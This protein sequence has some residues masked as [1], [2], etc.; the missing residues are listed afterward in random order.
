MKTQAAAEPH[1]TPVE[2]LDWA[3][4]AAHLDDNGFAVTPPLLAAEACRALCALFDQDG[5]FRKTVN[6]ARHNYGRGLY[7][8][9]DYPLPGAVGRLRDHLYPGLAAI[10]NQWAGRLGAPAEWP[11]ELPALLDR[12]HAAGQCKP[13]PLLLRYGPGDYNR[14]HQDLYGD[15]HFPLQVVIQLSEPGREFEGGELVLVEQR[16]RQQSRPMVVSL[17]QGAAAIIPV[18]ERPEA[19]ARGVRRVQMR[20]GVS[21][22]R[23]G[24]RTTLGL[25]FHDAQ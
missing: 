25:I 5:H 16:P 12:C 23:S 24:Q 17:P 10:A 14:L 7:R 11:A 22:V 8:Y 13:T 15:I 3:A 19:G 21:Q 9:F 20:H 2:Q 4:L 6:M 1:A 18:R